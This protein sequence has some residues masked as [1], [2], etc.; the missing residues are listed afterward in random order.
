MHEAV[1]AAQEMRGPEERQQL[2]KC[3]VDARKGKL[4]SLDPGSSGCLPCI[5]P[6]GVSC[7]MCSKRVC[8]MMQK[9]EGN[10]PTCM[11]QPTLLQYFH[12][13]FFIYRDPEPCEK[14]Q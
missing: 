14:C 9:H 1:L 13:P 6:V 7:E 2:V 10:T 5:E 3:V 4:L 11:V 8:V 12:A